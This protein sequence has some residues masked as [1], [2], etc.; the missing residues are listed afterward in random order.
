MIQ[1]SCKSDKN[2]FSGFEFSVECLVAS[3]DCGMIV[4]MELLLEIKKLHRF[5]SWWRTASPA[6][7]SGRQYCMHSIVCYG[8]L[9]A[10]WNVLVMISVSL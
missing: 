6:G 9:F 5:C 8:C 2:R 3:R 7:N 10:A 1:V 4:D